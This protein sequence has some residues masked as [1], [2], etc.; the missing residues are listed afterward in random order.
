MKKSSKD[1]TQ[2]QK[3]ASGPV[4]DPS[5]VHLDLIRNGL[6]GRIAAKKPNLRKRNRVKRLSYAKLQ[7]K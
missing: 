2:D 1:L 3:N 7:K 4:V 5:N 6:S